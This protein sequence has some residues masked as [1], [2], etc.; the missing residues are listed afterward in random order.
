MKQPLRIGIG[1]N[2]GNRLRR[3]AF[4]D[5]IRR[6]LNYDSLSAL[7]VQNLEQSAYRTLDEAAQSVSRAIKPFLNKGEWANI[8]IDQTK[9][10][11]LAE[12]REIEVTTKG[13]D[14]AVE[15]LKD[16]RIPV[17][18]GINELERMYK[19][20]IQVDIQVT[21]SFGKEIFIHSFVSRII[22]YVQKSE[23]LTIES[24]VNA[25]AKFA[26][27][28]CEQ[29]LHIHEIK[30]CARKPS[31]LNFA[32]SAGVQ[33]TRKPSDFSIP[34]NTAQATDQGKNGVYLAFGTNQGNRLKNV[35]QS[36]DELSR[37]KVH[38][39]RCSAL[40]Q[41]EPMYYTDQ[42]R[43]LNGVF[44]C[45]TELEPQALLEVLKDIEYNVF[46]RVKLFDNGPR[47][48]DLDI[49]LYNNDLVQADNLT[50]PHRDMLNR[51]FVLR[52]LNDLLSM[53]ARYTEISE[54]GE[55]T[56]VP[57][58]IENSP[59]VPE[60]LEFD[61]QYPKKMGTKLM[62]IMNATPDS[63]SD[64]GSLHELNTGSVASAHIQDGADIIDVGGY[65]T[66]P[67]ALH[68]SIEEETRRVCSAIQQI[69]RHCP[70]SVISVDTFRGSVAR[71]A[72]KS[73]ANV[74]NDVFSGSMDPAILKVAADTGAPIILSH[75]RGTPETIKMLTDYPEGVIKGVCS[76]LRSRVDQAL[77]LGCKPWQVI[78]D[79]GLG[80]AK[81]PEQDLEL[82]RN[83]KE[84]KT[85]PLLC[86]RLP[87]FPWL[88]GPSR[89]SFI[90]H[91]VGEKE[92][93]Q[94]LAGTLAAATALVQQGADII[95]V[96]DTKAVHQA[97]VLAD[98]IF[99]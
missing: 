35:K 24:F 71:E 32:D 29:K 45:R 20:E 47:P 89:K 77:S 48:L 34:I 6:T 23:F 18:I 13:S 57:L 2:V 8:S 51:S 90:G 43:F 53:D 61:P 93:R 74:I 79:P 80:F 26:L 64:R 76:E 55:T 59:E 28:S 73:G 91:F 44:E 39:T 54:G 11:L 46:N 86:D 31:A 17:I 22:E 60:Y 14:E 56:V 1:I 65:S 58:F 16:L 38:V 66:R 9:A 37:R 4:T 92:P 25:L 19:Q 94:R 99:V 85:S 49:V 97:L 87:V 70:K 33:V 68:V 5:D 30:V 95:R 40:Y 88:I 98:K 41:S 15:T 12:S 81:T 21:R 78:L 27:Q 62:A 75:A 84:L 42:P 52:P 69:R 63:F 82:I 67:G 3:M 83:F 50:I 7:I 96:H 10:I 36:I 72:L